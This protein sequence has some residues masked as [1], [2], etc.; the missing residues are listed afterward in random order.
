VV[1]D[2]QAQLRHS[3]GKRRRAKRKRSRAAAVEETARTRLVV[4]LLGESSL[5]VSGDPGSGKSTFCRWVAWLAATGEMPAF[6]V[7]APDAFRESLPVSLRARLP[8]LVPLREFREHLPAHPGRRSLTAEQFH[9]ALQHWLDKTRP[10]GLTWSDVASHLARG[11]LL[12]ILD[13]IDELPASDG[14]GAEAWSPREAWLARLTAAATGWLKDQNRLLATSRPYGLTPEQVR[15]LARAGLVEASLDPLPDELQDLLAARWFVALP[16]TSA[17]GRT[18][19][20]TMLKQVRQ[21][22]GDVSALV[23]NPLLL[24]AICIIYSEDKALP[25][26]KHDLYHRI[27]NTALC[28]RYPRGATVIEPVR[29]RLAAVAL[30]M[31]TGQPYQPSRQSPVAEVGYDELDQILGEYMRATPETESEFRRVLDARDDLLSHSGLLSQREADRARFYHL[32]FQ[33]FLAAE[34]LVLLNRNEDDLLEVFRR[35]APLPGWRPTLAF[36][37]GSR[38]AQ[39]G[40]Q[41]GVELL[42]RILA[43]ID[44]GDVTN[45]LGLA[46]SSVDALEIP[47]GQELKLQEPLLQQFRTIALA[48]IQQDVELKARAELARMLGRVGDPR[49]VDD[50]NDPAAWVEVE[51]GTYRVGDQELAKE[52]KQEYSWWTDAV[53]PDETV[54]FEQPFWLSKYPVTNGQYARFVAAR[55]YD[56]RQLWHPAGWKWREANDIREPVYWRDA[57][58]NGPTQPV[59][60]VSWWEADA[61]CR[62]AVC[63]L[64]TER[65]WE[66]AAR[67]PQGRAYPWPG[68]WRAGICNSVKAALGV[69]TPVGIFPGSAAVCGAHDMAGNVWEWCAYTFDASRADDPQA[70]RVLRG[71]AWY[72]LPDYC[73]CAVRHA[74]H[75]FNRCD[76][77]GFRAART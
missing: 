73:R 72:G 9:T 40:W 30:G 46:R 70:G 48:A 74:N 23:A 39:P 71:G 59:V 49:V 37:F 28:S 19:A 32:S 10:G 5:Y 25:Q 66:A 33:E 24:T 44:T 12:L 35:R 20:A 27:V 58:W 55:G 36:L 43:S 60:G 76:Y 17:A 77:V 3:A 56:N 15:Q 64:P 18:I 42:K 6:E 34:R 47:L 4:D 1:D 14:E 41:A 8:V 50:L 57:K 51:A 16:K 53:L 26:D 29:K 68:E 54:C 31:H 52:I 45:S 38:V 69:T 65:E 62:W 61:F 63:R 2:D 21:L 75:A 67:G 13:G 11:S 7:A 22:H